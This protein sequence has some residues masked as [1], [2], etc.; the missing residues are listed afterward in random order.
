MNFSKLAVLFTTLLASAA[1]M[2]H[3]GHIETSN[4]LLAGLL[5][6]LTGLDHLAMGIGLGLLMART[7]RMS[8]YRGFAILI[9]TLAGGFAMGVAGTF[10]ADMAEF[11]ISVSLIVLATALWMRTKSAFLVVVAGLG[12]FHGIA[13]GAEIP[14][15]LDPAGFLVGM[16]MTLSGLYVTGMA[17]SRWLQTHAAQYGKGFERAASVL[18]GS[19][20][21]LG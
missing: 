11:G 5:H 15:G 4:A 18:T 16:L 17:I 10:P 1:A 19:V 21:F 20:V 9:G 6:P 7:L 13:H 14:A 3:P 2:A 12:L 8:R